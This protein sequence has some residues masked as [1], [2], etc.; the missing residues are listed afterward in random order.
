M[1]SH[2]DHDLSSKIENELNYVAVKLVLKKYGYAAIGVK[3]VSTNY[4]IIFF[5]LLF[6]IVLTNCVLMY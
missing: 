1:N 4:K 2:F 6:I 3:Y 5:T